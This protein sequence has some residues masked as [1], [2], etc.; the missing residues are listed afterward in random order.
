MKTLLI[1]VLS[2]AL[3]AAAFM[4]RPGRGQFLL[5]CIDTQLPADR[6][7]T[8]S[9]FQYADELVK[10]VKIKDRILWVDIERDGKV[11]YTGCFAHFFPRN[12]KG[13]VGLPP[14]GE[15]AKLLA[16]AE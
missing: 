11:I 10:S 13:E 9:D 8:P 12:A 2:L 5:Y 7:H 6:Q 4:T 16:K 14:A 1:L 3:L 15:I